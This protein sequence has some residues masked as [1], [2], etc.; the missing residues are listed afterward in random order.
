M[1]LIVIACLL[2]APQECQSHHLR[3][4]LTGGDPGQCMYSSLPRVSR[5]QVMHPKWK[6]KS[7]HC[8]LVGLEERI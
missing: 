4:T 1:E 7:W 3:L 5:W 8:A 6:V 2:S